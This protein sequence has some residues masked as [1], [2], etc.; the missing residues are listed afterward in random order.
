MRGVKRRARARRGLFPGQRCD[1]RVCPGRERRRWRG[2]AAAGLGLARLPNDRWSGPRHRPACRSPWR[3]AELGAVGAQ[4]VLA[5]AEVVRRFPDGQRRSLE[6]PREFLERGDTGGQRPNE[7]F[8]GGDIAP[9]LAGARLVR[10]VSARI[11]RRARRRTCSLRAGRTLGMDKPPLKRTAVSLPGLPGNANFGRTHNCPPG[12]TGRSGRSGGGPN[13]ST[14]PLGTPSGSLAHLELVGPAVAADC[15]L[16][17]F[18][19]AAGP[20]FL[21]GDRVWVCS[22]WPIIIPEVRREMKIAGFHERRRRSLVPG[23]PL[24]DGLGLP[25]PVGSRR[26]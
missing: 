5:E 3:K 21:A 16:K 9:M 25:I 19:W 1:A 10:A 11:S 6:A 15:R 17:G 13:E 7:T 12:R 26:S 8:E 4:A 23:R 18:C 14:S 22:S 20:G 2:V 24:R